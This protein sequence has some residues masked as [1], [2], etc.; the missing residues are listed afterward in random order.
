VG[1]EW[2]SEV[3][4]VTVYAVLMT[5]VAWLAVIALW[6]AMRWWRQTLDGWQRSLDRERFYMTMLKESLTALSSL[7]PETAIR[8]AKRL[9]DEESA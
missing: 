3:A 2:N 7:E 9:Q 6:G 4:A 5:V 8:L 1:S